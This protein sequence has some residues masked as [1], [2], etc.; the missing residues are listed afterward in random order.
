MKALVCEGFTHK[1]S[2][3]R[4]TITLPSQTDI[5]YTISVTPLVTTVQGFLFLDTGNSNLAQT[6]AKQLIIKYQNT[7]RNLD[8]RNDCLASILRIV[9][10]IKYVVWSPLNQNILC[11][12]YT[13]IQTYKRRQNQVCLQ[14]P[15]VA[16][17]IISLLTSHDDGRGDSLQEQINWTSLLD[18]VETPKLYVWK[19]N[20]QLFTTM[21]PRTGGP[22][23][24]PRQ[25][26]VVRK[27]ILPTL[28]PPL[29]SYLSFLISLLTSE[30][31]LC[32]NHLYCFTSFLHSLPNSPSFLSL[33]LPLCRWNTTL[34]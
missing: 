7:R 16:Q 3:K 29:L 13:Q 2:G 30:T 6:S 27:P 18:L 33:S 23:T 9:K 1:R 12:S 14:Q 8:A 28:S 32:T 31:L 21:Q 26:Y 25:S 20:H 22:A 17:P 24:W 34:G 10:T 19:C 11:Q 5:W 4:T 15:S